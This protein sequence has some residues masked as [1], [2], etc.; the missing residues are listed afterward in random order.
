MG[1]E[2]NVW[3]RMGTY[4]I[5]VGKKW[6]YFVVREFRTLMIHFD[7]CN[8]WCPFSGGTISMCSIFAVT[9]WL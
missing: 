1:T 8:Q 2:M 7:L 6:I 4:C 9:G 5:F 3:E